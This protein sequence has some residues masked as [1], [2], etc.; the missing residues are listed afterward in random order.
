MKL[1]DKVAIITGGGGGLGRE[2]AGAFAREG[3]IQAL[4]DINWSNLREV[5]GELKKSKAEAL[6]IKADISKEGEVAGVVN[7]VLEKYGRVDILVNNAGVGFGTHQG[8][9]PVKELTLKAWQNVLDINLT[10][11]FLCSRAVLDPMIRQK[12]GNIINISS[13][14]GKKG[15]A[16]YAAYSVSKF[17]IEALTQV[18]AQEVA[19]HNIRVNSLA[20]GGIMATP[21]VLARQ[22]TDLSELLLP[23]VIRE[24]IVYLASDEAAG[25]TGQSV[26]ATEW[27]KAHG[28]DN[29][30]YVVEWKKA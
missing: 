15:I 8:W 22:R 4:V 11:A 30:V 9:G 16:T 13:G 29:S 17:G 12:R 24:A 27:N 23:S 6:P 19:P 2:I 1:K 20:P 5:A 7:K 14:M 21:P 3:A 25:I 10:G 18:L 28:I 26:T